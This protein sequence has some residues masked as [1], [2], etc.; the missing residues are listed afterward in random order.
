MTER[1][2]GGL[3][4]PDDSALM[5][6]VPVLPAFA[7][8][9][10]PVGAGL[11]LDSGFVSAYLVTDPE[12]WLAILEAPRLFIQD[13]ALDV[14]DLIAPLEIA[15]HKASP[16]VV[17]APALT[18]RARALVIINKL[19]GVLFA[20]AIETQLTAEVL[21]YSSRH[22]HITRVTSGTHTSLIE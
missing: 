19:R 8:P 1:T 18:A 2:P 6:D 12:Q 13:R 10:E 20:S 16:I 3:F 7:K 17:I 21:A 11:R 15:A 9:I 4:L 22:A 14:A 5:D